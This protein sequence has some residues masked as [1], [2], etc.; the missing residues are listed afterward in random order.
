MSLAVAR[1][2]TWR[3]WFRDSYLQFDRRSLGLTRICL[4]YYLIM[5]LFRRTPDWE[6]MFAGTGVLP[7]WVILARPQQQNFSLVHGFT[8]GPE[9]W[10]L[11]AV[12]LFSHTMLFIGW[13]TKIWQVLSLLF[14]T[15][16]NGRVLLIENGGYVVQ[17]LLL[18]WTAFLPLGDR[19]SVDAMRASL[20]RKR[21]TTVDALNDRGDHDDPRKL[22][23]FHSLVGVAIAL[24][25]SAIYYF[26][27]VH[28]TGPAW[29]NGTAVH[30]VLYNDRMAT[31][32]VA[33]VRTHV[34]FWL[35]KIA[36]PLVLVAEATI[37]FCMLLPRVQLAGFQVKKWL[38]RLAIFLIC[39][40]HIGFGSSFVLG[41]FAW[42]LCIFS[43]VLFSREDWDSAIRTMRR[44][45]RWRTVLLDPK[46][47]AALLAG[48]VLARLDRFALLDFE[49]ATP[50]ECG[51][52]GFAIKRPAGDVVQGH[53]AVAELVNA[54]PVGPV[55]GWL[56]LVPGIAQLVELA[57]RTA[58]G[59]TSRF[60]GLTLSGPA[61]IETPAVLG[62]TLGQRLTR[63]GVLAR[64]GVRELMVA[65]M[66]AAAVNQ[67][68][69][70][71]WS[72]KKP[73]SELISSINQT[74][75][76]HD[77]GVTLS[78][79][80][81]PLK[82]LSTKLR[83]LQG[84]FMFSPNPVMDD[85]T[86]IADAVT[87]DGR[88]IDPFWDQEPNYDLVHTESYRYNQ[89]WSDYFNRMHFAGNRPYYDSMV[90][91]MRRLPERTGDP[92]DR[93]VS[94]EVYWVSDMNP[95][96]GQRNSWNEKR[97]LL[98]TFREQGGATAAP[99]TTTQ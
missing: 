82:I 96:W 41:P 18:L 8:T 88:H 56:A 94:G 69:V 54:L 60:F 90:D 52:F 63:F 15:S 92:S 77:L 76:A 26:N 75:P 73:W 66:L 40:L 46:S 7:N 57:L 83:F 51:R 34:P 44:S 61:A 16:M 98:F 50:S 58:R 45:A 6:H 97:E 53:R 48:R 32:I 4:G 93:I 30:F 35:I 20:R 91:Y 1:T 17:N 65:A 12:I 39:L 38:R 25:F 55:F 19:F 36:T 70:E 28:K 31:P 71:L 27:V 72:T 74:G 13:R 78:P 85:G 80:P 22:L 9:L 2:E 21:E 81:E 64:A 11:W 43:T 33:A 49:E 86:I 29:H 99:R 59:R 10:A 23:P 42:A 14:V 67:A 68:L 95:K 62:P 89:I 79:Q 87:A 84:W 37:P 3:E 47:G 24:Q 5:D